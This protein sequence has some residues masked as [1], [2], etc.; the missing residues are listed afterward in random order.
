[1]SADRIGDWPWSGLDLDGPP[2]DRRTIRR[3]Y[4]RI[5][6]T[7]DQETEPRRFEALRKAYDAAMDTDLATLPE[8][9]ATHVEVAPWQDLPV[10]DDPAPGPSERDA[11]GE[12][13]LDTDN[14]IGNGTKGQEWLDDWDSWGTEPEPADLDP[15]IAHTDWDATQKLHDLVLTCK[16]GELATTIEKVLDDPLMVDPHSLGSV[17]AAIVTRLREDMGDDPRN[18]TLNSQVVAALDAR[19]GWVSDHTALRPS[20]PWEPDPLQTGLI[21]EAEDYP[22]MRVFM[23][24]IDAMKFAVLYATSV[25]FLARWIMVTIIMWIAILLIPPFNPDLYL[26]LGVTL[27]PLV[28]ALGSVAL[29]VFLLVPMGIYVLISLACYTV[30][31]VFM[32]EYRLRK[33]CH[34]VPPRKTG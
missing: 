27:A 18:L 33:C 1:M 17:H 24:L 29:A 25:K 20:F 6:K 22:G 28:I 23:L 11:A 14:D 19:F 32:D 10:A 13:A 26:R 8:P 3:A 5:L 34:A 15:D 21:R 12:V 30:W 31:V 9:A 4:A 2:A 16:P 7:I